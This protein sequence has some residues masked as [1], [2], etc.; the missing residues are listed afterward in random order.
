MHDPTR[1]VDPGPARPDTSDW[2]W[3][4]VR[5]CPQCGYDSGHVLPIGVP[6]IVR[7]A[8]T[9]YA[10]VLGRM[11]VAVR[12]G[13]GVWSPLEYA[14]HVRDVCDVMRGRLERILAGDGT[15]PVELDNWD[16]DATAVEKQYWR[17]DPGQVAVELQDAFEA[18]AAAF[19]TPHRA[20]WSWSAVRSDGA[21]FTV[22]TLA[23]YFVHDLVHH[24]WD[25]QG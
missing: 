17:A 7:D 25:V 21:M 10:A 8:A 3:V 14:C 12:P 6:Q 16:Q 20:Q 22:E 19:A 5:P 15:T 24:L 1:A 18:A 2:T 4:L 13:E 9:R 11:D 23:K